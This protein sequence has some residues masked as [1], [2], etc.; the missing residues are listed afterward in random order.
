MHSMLRGRLDFAFF[1]AFLAASCECP[2]QFPHFIPNTP[3]TA[4]RTVETTSNNGVS[5]LT[6]L[7][8]RRSDGSTYVEFRNPNG[9]NAI[10]TAGYATIVDLTKQVTIQLVFVNHTYTVYPSP[11]LRPAIKFPQSV[12]QYMSSWGPAGTKQTAGDSVTTILGR[13]KV[14]GLDVMGFLVTNARG[15]FERWYSPVLQ[16]DVETKNHQTAP[17]RISVT[18]VSGIRLGEPDPGLFEIP[19]GYK[20]QKGMPKMPTPVP[21]N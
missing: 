6:G 14:E 21:T 8:A 4:T 13:G 16:E 20:E 11:G 1:L 5:T 7:V 18:T 10:Q 12:E 15:S 2:A 17:E 9:A 3:F 19:A